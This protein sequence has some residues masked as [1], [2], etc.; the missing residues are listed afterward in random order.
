MREELLVVANDLPGEEEEKRGLITHMYMYMYIM[1]MYMYNCM[2]CT[3]VQLHV[4][5][6][7]TVQFKHTTLEAKEEDLQS[8]GVID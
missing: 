5:H 3:V 8:M 4:S 2:T 7:Y 6:A 1:Y